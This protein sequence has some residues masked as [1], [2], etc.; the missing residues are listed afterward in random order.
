M[1][2]AKPSAW[3]IYMV[4]CRDNTLYTGITDNLEKRIEAHN[5]GKGAKYIVP[6]RRPVKCVW[7]KKTKTRNRAL[8]L[9]IEIKR[10]S[11]TE[12]EKLVKY[13]KIKPIV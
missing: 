10:M 1:K 3:T 9:E 2:K 6:S 4:R 7:V 12:K 11:K 5:S 8:K 13:G